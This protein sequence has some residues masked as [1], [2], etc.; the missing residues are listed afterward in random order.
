MQCRFTGS[1]HRSSYLAICCWTKR[2]T[3]CRQSWRFIRLFS[4][5]MISSDSPCVRTSDGVADT[6]DET[7]LERWTRSD[8]SRKDSQNDARAQAKAVDGIHRHGREKARRRKSAMIHHLQVSELCG[9]ADEVFA[10]PSFDL[11]TAS[12]EPCSDTQFLKW[13]PVPKGKGHIPFS[14]LKL[15]VSEFIIPSSSVHRSLIPLPSLWCD[16]PFV[17]ALLFRILKSKVTI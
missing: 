8:L 11:Q 5:W 3:H 14:P 9:T 7:V 17:P 13:P 15:G 2:H 12:S 1:L 10:S 16:A 4:P 6:G